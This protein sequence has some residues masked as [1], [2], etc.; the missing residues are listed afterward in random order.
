MKACIIT[1][2]N[3]EN[4][5]SFWQ[6]KALEA[7]L[8]S[9]GYDVYFLKRK[10]KYS[11][12]SFSRLMKNVCT[13]LLNTNVTAALTAIRQYIVFSSG[14]RQ[15]RTVKTCD[16]SFNLCVL[17]SDTI[18]NLKSKYF[19]VN[20]EA[21]FGGQSRAKK[22]ISYAASIGNSNKSD[23]VKYPELQHYLNELD[24]IT[25]RDIETQNTVESIT[26]KSAKLVCDPTLLFDKD[27]Y[28]DHV[29]PVF[30]TNS[31]F[32]YYFNKIPADLVDRIYAFARKNDLKIVVMG[33][34]MKGDINYAYDPKV[35]IECFYE[36]Q[37]VV[38]NTFHGTLFS[39]I[40]EKQAVFHS[41][42]KKKVQDI[43]SRFGL[44]HQDYDNVDDKDELFQCSRIDYKE[45]RRSLATF[46]QDS[47]VF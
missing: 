18:W 16:E 42:G 17:G 47:N 12:H 45:V 22:T 29:K 35:F 30:R 23:I 7:Y 1:V 36:A 40:F 39:L 8:I 28:L 25:V 32:V 9:R 34:S 37:F 21:Y 44:K 26:N 4:C 33:N 14:A 46:R 43:L 6:A 20:R 3:S 24:L 38:T 5:G 2:Y 10:M 31:V 27:F 19:V 15:F 11:S 13:E 41:C